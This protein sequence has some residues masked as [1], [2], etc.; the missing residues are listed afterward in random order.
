[1]AQRTASASCYKPG[2]ALHGLAIHMARLQP[3]QL[4]T[5]I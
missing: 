5:N 4:T 3:I 1:M 2:S